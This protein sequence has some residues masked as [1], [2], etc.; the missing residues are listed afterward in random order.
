[1]LYWLTHMGAPDSPLV[2]RCIACLRSS[3]R[4]NLW[5][6]LFRSRFAVGR[7]DYIICLAPCA[8]Q[9]ALDLLSNAFDLERGIACQLAGLTPSA[10]HHFVDSSFDS[11]LIHRPPP[12]IQ[13]Y[14][15]TEKERN[16]GLLSSVKLAFSSA[17]RCMSYVKE[18]TSEKYKVYARV[19]WVAQR[20]QR[21]PGIDVS[22]LLGGRG[23]RHPHA[24]AHRVLHFP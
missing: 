13:L 1:M 11:I 14:R 4:L 7:A 22:A 23:S 3:G 20:I 8:F 16:R 18:L 24:R 10:S 9:C 17:S 6:F 19:F 15:G 12:W 5:S 21:L 2:R